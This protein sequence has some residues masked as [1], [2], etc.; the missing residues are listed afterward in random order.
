MLHFIDEP[1]E[2]KFLEPPLYSKSP[3]CPDAFLWNGIWF[4]VRREI[5]SW[6]DFARHGRMGRNMQPAHAVRASKRGSWGVGRF[7]FRVETTENREFDIYFDR[8][9]KD[10]DDRMGSWFLLGERNISD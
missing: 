9:P 1:I 8:A 5:S 10:A 4:E 3:P 6:A 2:V 7:F